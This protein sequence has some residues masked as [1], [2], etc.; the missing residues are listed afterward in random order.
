MASQKKNENFF[1]GLVTRLEP[2]SIPRG[3]ASDSLNF[4]TK[5]DRIEL[6]RG[7]KLLGTT[8]NTGTGKITGLRVG[9]REDGTQ[10]AFRTRGRKIEYYDTATEEWI[11]SGSDVLPVAASG[12]D[13]SI[14]P[15]QNLAGAFM[16][17]SSPNSS[18]YKIHLANPG[19]VTDLS[20]TAFRGK[21]T[22][23]QNRML[24]WDQKGS[25]G[26]KDDTGVYGSYVDKDEVTDYTQISAEA[27]GA[28][29]SLTYTGTLAFKA[30]GAKRTCFEVTFT[31]GTET[32]V[33]NRNG[34]LVGTAGGTGTINYTT[35]AYSVTFAA[36]AGGSVTSTYRWEDATSAGIA[37]FSKSSP[38]TA[39][40][41]FVF[42]QDDGGG[43]VQ[44]ILTYEAVTYCLHR[45]KTWVIEI[46]NTDTSATNLPFRD[47]A[48]IP[49]WR[50]AEATGDG[51]YYVDDTDEND[52]MVRVMTLNQY[53]SKVLPKGISTNLDLSGYEFD[54]AIIREWGTKIVLACR[55]DDATVNNRLFIYDKLLKSWDVHDYICSTLDIYNG[56]LIA[57][58][59][60]TNNVY[61]LFSGLD[62]DDSAIVGYWQ[63]NLDSLDIDGMKK[64]KRFKIGG[65]IGPDQKMKVSLSVDG[66]AFVEI[67][68]SDD[69]TVS[70]AVHTYAIEGTGSY[71]DKT[72]AVTVGSLVIGSGEVGGGSDGIQAY[73]Y[74]RE[75][76]TGQDALEQ[77]MVRVEPVGDTTGYL[78]VSLYQFKDVR[79]KGRKIPLKYR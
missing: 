56:T 69:T 5:G 32:F 70:P 75:F 63:G 29:G 74:E 4:V 53:T 11:E 9:T 47:K 45:L 79:F 49:Y 12:E 28:A 26:G 21:M 43:S 17:F 46:T 50:A 23:S 73:N 51:I 30:A 3:A 36:V 48:G 13:I 37:D 65:L 57:G 40:Q 41:G 1:T 62:D 15:Y 77:V 61:T 7:S 24:L 33:D 2:Q 67:G 59:P 44:R 6:R 54:Y 14:E 22:I 76:A 38:R 25:T 19:S 58:D 60:A 18:I 64:P 31:D 34:V 39:G 8:L 27:I 35:G 68:G 55:T 42:R 16:Y 71:V 72:Q 20:S 10:V 52:P 78:S 66:G